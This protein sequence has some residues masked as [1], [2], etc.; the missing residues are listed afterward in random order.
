MCTLVSSPTVSPL[1]AETPSPASPYRT[2]AKQCTFSP[3]MFSYKERMSPGAKPSVQAAHPHVK[4]ERGEGSW[5]GGRREMLSYR[6]R[7]R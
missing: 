6:D 7:D 5:T 2:Q 1:V 4:E 3:F